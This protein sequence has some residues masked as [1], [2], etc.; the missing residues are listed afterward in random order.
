MALLGAVLGGAVL[1][2]GITLEAW[3]AS[4]M[5][6]FTPDYTTVALTVVPVVVVVVLIL[7]GAMPAERLSCPEEARN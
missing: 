4:G 1:G 6:G 2:G 7:A 3:L 5:T